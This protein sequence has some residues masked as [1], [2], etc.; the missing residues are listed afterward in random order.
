MKRYE[1]VR[2]QTLPDLQTRVQTFI[3]LEHAEVNGRPFWDEHERVW[4][5]SILIPKRGTKDGEVLLRE[6]PKRK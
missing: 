4:I 5:Q 2:A 1:I 6:T 3:D